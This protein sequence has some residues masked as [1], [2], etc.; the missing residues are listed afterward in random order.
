MP[1]HNLAIDLTHSQAKKAMKGSGIRIKPDQIGKGHLVVHPVNKKHIEKAVLKSKGFTLE[2]SP[3]EL[4]ETAMYHIN[5]HGMEGSGFWSSIWKGIKKTWNFL[6][7]SGIATKALDA[8]VMPLS[9]Y[10][11]QPQLVAAARQGVRQLA[12]VGLPKQTKKTKRDA[13]VA[14][15]LYLS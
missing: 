2:L 8:A 7:D 15:G 5:K 4:A 3:A 1:Y 11:G 12:G 14:K 6:K 9:A 10:T 13:L